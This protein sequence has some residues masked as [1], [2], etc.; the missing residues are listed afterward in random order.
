MKI[1]NINGKIKKNFLFKFWEK[2]N[3]NLNFGKKSF[4]ILS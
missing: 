2:I 4:E 1:K 3:L